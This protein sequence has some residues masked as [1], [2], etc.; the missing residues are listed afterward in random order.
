MLGAVDIFFE[1]VVGLSTLYKFRPNRIS[2]VIISGGIA[3]ARIRYRLE[4]GLNLYGRLAHTGR[5]RFIM[6]VNGYVV[7]ADIMH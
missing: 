2:C 6:G 3:R 7:I 1:T 4:F 5:G